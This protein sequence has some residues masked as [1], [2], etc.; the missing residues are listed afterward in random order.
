M[1]TA[2]GD[3]KVL[4]DAVKGEEQGNGGNSQSEISQTT[5]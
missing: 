2:L 3:E 4:G 1:A 5:V